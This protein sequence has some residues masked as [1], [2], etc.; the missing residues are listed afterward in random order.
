V[1][2]VTVR[3]YISKG[4]VPAVKVGGRVRVRESDIKR[5][6]LPIKRENGQKSDKER[7]RKAIEMI[8]AV[9]SRSK[10]GKPSTEELIRMVRGERQHTRLKESEKG[11]DSMAKRSIKKVSKAE[12]ARRKKLM[13]EAR[14]LRDRQPPLG[15]STA[16]LVHLARTEREWLYGR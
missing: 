12:L 4:T 10:P 15:M 7:I 13:E 16:E 3:R 6:V 9:R 8:Y 5:V 2:E 1:H 14:K 11:L